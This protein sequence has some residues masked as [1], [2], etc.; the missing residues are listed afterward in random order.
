MVSKH[1]NKLG[2]RLRLILL[3]AATLVTLLA[4]GLYAAR[5]YETS[6]AKS[7][8]IRDQAHRALLLT[9]ELELHL[10][11]ERA[12]WKTVLLRGQQPDDYHAYLAE[13]YDHE[14]ETRA[15]LHELGRLMA[16]DAQITAAIAQLADA[17]LRLGKVLREAIRLF[18]DTL[19]KSHLAA[20][21]MT[22]TQENDPQLLVAEVRSLVERHREQSLADVAAE[23]A[24][25][26]TLFLLILFLVGGGSAA[27]FVWLLDVNIGKPAQQAAYLANY[28]TLTGL[29]NRTLFQDRLQH[30]IA[31]ADRQGSSLALLFFD[32]DHFKAVNDA[33]GHHVGDQLLTQ[34]GSRLLNVVRSS[35]TAARLG[36]DEF[37]VIVENAADQ[38]DVLHVANH[39]I[40]TLNQ[41]FTVADRQ[42]YV[43]ASLGIT[44]YPADAEDANNLLKNADAAMYLAKQKGRGQYHFFTEELN[45]VAE[46]RLQLETQLRTA[47][48][49]HRFELHFQPQMALADGRLVG[50]EALLRFKSTDELVA[51][52]RFIPVLEDTGL[53]IPVGEWVIAEACRWGAHWQATTG[54]PLRVAVNLSVRQLHDRSLPDKV[55]AILAETGFPEPCLEL[56][57][58]EGDLLDLTNTGKVLSDLRR[59]GVRLAIDDFGTGYSS[60]SYLKSFAVD[61]LKIDR[62]FIRDIHHDRDDDAVTS[63]IIALAH[64]LEIE[65]IAEGVETVEQQ[66]FLTLQGCDL[67]QGYLLSRPLP[68]EVFEEW[69]GQRLVRQRTLL[70]QNADSV[71]L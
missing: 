16:D 39:I 32:L 71:G 51:P 42:A 67:A 7:S 13:F 57:I 68:A 26:K 36:G 56:E 45:R 43:S 31:Q 33:L 4:L 48:A 11:A 19:D 20:D 3:F 18:N 61:L 63:A 25:A 15:T 69:L 40:E 12:A 52:D 55:A 65:V 60:L 8:A 41:P 53:I 46:Q 5:Y 70:P 35:D 2:I 28:D 10:Q 23:D 9:S 47:L 6:L 54:Y 64:K 27:L 44:F 1:D 59:L 22:A 50:A 29:P 21:R 17:H 34:A 62:S 58:T 38:A 30:A 49:E 37:A 66:A 14:R 24:E